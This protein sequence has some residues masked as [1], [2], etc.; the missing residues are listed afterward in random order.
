MFIIT[1]ATY[2][3][4]HTVHVIQGKFKGLTDTGFTKTVQ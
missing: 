3:A 2:I 4:L 1:N